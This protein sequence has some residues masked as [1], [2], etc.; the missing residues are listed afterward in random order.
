MTDKRVQYGLDRD[1]ARDYAE[2]VAGG[3]CVAD[4]AAFMADLAEAS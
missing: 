4:D 2:Q 1:Y 3:D